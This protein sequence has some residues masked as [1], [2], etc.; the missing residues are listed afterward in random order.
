[1]VVIELKI[2]GKK[3]PLNRYV[4]DV[5]LKVIAALISTLKGVPED[6]SELELVIK[7]DED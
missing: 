2:D 7:K 1:M 3:I 4:S 6:W 5:F